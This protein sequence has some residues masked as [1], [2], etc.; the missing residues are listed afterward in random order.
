MDRPLRNVSE[1]FEHYRCAL[2][3]LWNVFFWDRKSFRHWD[4]ASHFRRIKRDLF[5]ALVMEEIGLPA[6]IDPKFDESAV[7]FLVIPRFSDAGLQIGE[8]RGATTGWGMQEPHRISKG[9]AD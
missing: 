9:E 8:E 7:P 5:L 2:Q 4:S 1:I 3:T 6:M